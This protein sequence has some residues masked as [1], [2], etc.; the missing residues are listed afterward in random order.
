ML[1]V[2]AAASA[3]LLISVGSGL[4]RRGGSFSSVGLP[5]KPGGGGGS[6]EIVV[7]AGCVGRAILLEKKSDVREDVNVGEDVELEEEAAA[8]DLV[9]VVI[10]VNVVVTRGGTV[11]PVPC[12]EMVFVMAG[13]EDDLVLLAVV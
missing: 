4:V 8:P 12:D 11:A 3:P 7:V 10:D 5:V 1:R 2:T 13:E 6:I 9:E